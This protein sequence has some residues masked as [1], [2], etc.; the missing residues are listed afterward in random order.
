MKS[1]QFS[2]L[3][4]PLD[5]S[6]RSN[7]VI[8]SVNLLV[9]LAAFVY[10]WGYLDT[11]FWESVWWSIQAA[12]SVF[13]AWALGREIDPDINTTAFLA[14]PI[15]LA[16]FY[17]F[18]SF[19]WVLLLA[20]LMMLRVTSHI[21]GQSVKPTDAILCLGLVGYLCWQGHTL[22]GFAFTAAFLADSRL[23][24]AHKA[25]QWYALIALLITIISLLFFPTALAE[26]T[27]QFSGW[28]VAGIALVSLIFIGV[29]ITY[30]RPGS[31]EDYREEMLNGRRMQVAQLIILTTGLLIYLGQDFTHTLAIAPVWAVI[32][33]ADLVH[34][35]RWITKIKIY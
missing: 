17:I 5:M 31:T 1:T 14:A 10:Q 9:L 35:L 16:F 8:A 2:A 32:L 20:F 26:H 7:L 21:C 34:L 15:S 12:L 24:P 25:S 30:Q 3:A 11:E 18:G 19:N 27:F 29:I 28:W 6:Y 33:S 13:L 23:A 4:R 22:I